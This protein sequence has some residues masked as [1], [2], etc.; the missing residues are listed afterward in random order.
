M[1][2][3]KTPRTDEFA[4]SGDAS[5]EDWT[6]FARELERDLAASQA[7]V[8]EIGKALATEQKY[9]NRWRELRKMFYYEETF[10]MDAAMKSALAEGERP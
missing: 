3:T 10:E 8:E 1:S 5:A 9:A 4:R 7:R 6:D 2:E